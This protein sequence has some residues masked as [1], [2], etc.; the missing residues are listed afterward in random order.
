MPRLGSAVSHDPMGMRFAKARRPEPPAV[1]PLT[2]PSLARAA[3]CRVFPLMD[4]HTLLG[5]DEYAPDPQALCSVYMPRI[6]ASLA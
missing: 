1:C 3:A 6:L 5:R 2:A 4:S